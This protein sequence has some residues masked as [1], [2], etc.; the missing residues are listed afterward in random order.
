[1][2]SIPTVILPWSEVKTFNI[3]FD[4]HGQS[5]QNGLKSLCQRRI[6]EA[7][8]MPG[9]TPS[10]TGLWGGPKSLRGG[11]GAAGEDRWV[12]VP[13][14]C[15]LVGNILTTGEAKLECTDSIISPSFTC[16][17]TQNMSTTRGT[18][19]LKELL[20]FQSLLN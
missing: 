7:P 8:A 13:A 12:G 11:A 4:G 18:L 6:L 20:A 9:I 5:G 10:A 2:A 15:W 14:N 3:Q 17:P 16:W 1:M 19:S